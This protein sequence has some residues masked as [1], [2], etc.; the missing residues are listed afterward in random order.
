M[1]KSENKVA[2]YSIVGF[3]GGHINGSLLNAQLIDEVS[4]LIIPIAGGAETF[5]T[6]FEKIY[7]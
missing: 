5:S 3:G 1:S 2:S 4:L 6:L 7:F